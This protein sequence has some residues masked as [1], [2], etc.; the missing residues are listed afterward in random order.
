[1][2]TFCSLFEQILKTIPRGRFEQLAQQHRSERHA[3]GFTS[4][5]QF[6]AMMF[7]HLGRAQ[8][9]REIEHGLRSAEGKLNHLGIDVPKRSTLAYANAHRPWQLF[10]SV[11]YALLEQCRNVP[12]GKRRFTFRNKLMSIDSTTVELVSEMYAWARYNKSKG[13]IKMHLMLDHDGLLPVFANVTDGQTADITAAR[14]MP[15]APGTIAVFDRGYI[16]YR[17]FRKLTD[18]GV[19][20]VTRLKKNCQYEVLEERRP[21]RGIVKDQLVEVIDVRAARSPGYVPMKMRRVEVIDERTGK[22]VVIFSNYLTLGASTISRIYK[23]RWQIELFFKA[24]KQNLKIKTFIGTSA[25]AIRI[26][27]WTALIAMLLVRYLKLQSACAASLS[28]LFAMLRFHLFSYR[29]LWKWL[30]QPFDPLSPR[31][32]VQLSL[33]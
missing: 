13:A 18:E 10:E 9:L 32:S 22:L 31:R 25:N 11:F 12:T 6:V 26:Q 3:R 19:F 23:D 28:N 4:W 17:W 27:L 21:P 14:A 33:L 15:F 16:D 30:K 7:C 2:A 24:I 5:Q 8:S 1:M 29:D 20:F